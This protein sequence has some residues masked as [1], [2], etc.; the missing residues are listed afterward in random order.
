M[1]VTA[2]TGAAA[3]MV[4]GSTINSFLGMGTGKENAEVYLSFMYA[5]KNRALK[6]RIVK[7]DCIII[8]EISMIDS[9][10]F[11]KIR[12]VVNV[13]RRRQGAKP[14]QFIMFGD[15]LQLPAVSAQQN[16]FVFQSKTWN[17][18]KVKVFELKKVYR[19]TDPK[20]MEVLGRIRGGDLSDAD[21]AFLVENCAKEAHPDS[22][23]LFAK[24]DDAE[25]HNRIALGRIH[26]QTHRFDAID[27]GDMYALNAVTAQPNLFLKVGAL[28]MCLKNINVSAS[29]HR[30][31]NGSVGRV[32]SV[33]AVEAPPST[34]RAHISV[35]F[36]DAGDAGDTPHK[37]IHTFIT[38]CT[39]ENEFSVYKNDKIAATRYQIPLKLA[40][41]V[42]I[43]KSQGATFEKLTVNMHGCFADGQ[44]YV[45]LSRARTLA[46]MHITGLSS[47]GV[48]ASAV[49]LNF[50][51][52]CT[53][54]H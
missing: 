11:D 41:G 32:L 45:A 22:V 25:T 43:H 18:M 1:G 20:L 27:S 10:F 46:G 40:W 48:R 8:D 9:K 36:T 35:E 53:A 38:G 4:G 3:A 12:T 50:Y 44:A 39:T 47:R 24:N 30:L 2:S 52:N 13:V 33:D 54:F 28:V 21:R 6:E 31:V 15:F 51:K 14:V 29:R 19:Q 7:T 5:A 37:F 23:C 49:A 17:E 26:T 42:S 34:R 16:G